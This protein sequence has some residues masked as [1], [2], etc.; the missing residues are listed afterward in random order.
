MRVSVAF[1]KKLA[2]TVKVH[3]ADGEL[4][5][6]IANRIIEFRDGGIIDKLMTYN[7]Y[8]EASKANA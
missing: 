7:E 4:N 8:F 5:Q 1:L 3:C 2:L 6:T